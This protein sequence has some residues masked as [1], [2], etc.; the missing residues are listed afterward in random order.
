[1]S[2]NV[3]PV[4]FILQHQFRY[5]K[6]E[7]FQFLWTTI[8]N[9]TPRD[10]IK[11]RTSEVGYRLDALQRQFEFQII[12]SNS[13][14]IYFDNNRATSSF[15]TPLLQ[16]MVLQKPCRMAPSSI[17]I[18]CLCVLL[19]IA[20]P[21]MEDVTLWFCSTAFQML[22]H[23]VTANFNLPQ[24]PIRF[25]ATFSLMKMPRMVGDWRKKLPMTTLSVQILLATSSIKPLPLHVYPVTTRA[26]VRSHVNLV[27]LGHLS[28]KGVKQIA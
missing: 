3:R 27:V 4:T 24:L 1:M 25:P 2:R 15:I 14:R 21:G 19:F 12:T 8:R 13:R 18:C 9:N 10:P 7:S 22:S 11:Y 16:L 23:I 5:R 20:S 26:R 6:F 17:F 28:Q